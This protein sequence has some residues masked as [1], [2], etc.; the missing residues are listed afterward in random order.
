M[1]LT[2]TK[3]FLTTPK[4]NT[5]Q[6]ASKTNNIPPSFTDYQKSVKNNQTMT[7]SQLCLKFLF[8]IQQL[9]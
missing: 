9:A 3:I 5:L 8:Y 7:R 6:E 4:D 1:L 2:H